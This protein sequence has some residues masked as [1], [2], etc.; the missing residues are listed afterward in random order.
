MDGGGLGA[1]PVRRLDELETAEAVLLSPGS[2]AT[3]PRWR[4]C[5]IAAFR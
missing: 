4:R 2:A 5:S 1:V 3:A